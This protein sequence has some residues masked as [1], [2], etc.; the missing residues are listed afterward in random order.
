MTTLASGQNSPNALSVD[1][2]SVYWVND[3]DGT[4]LKLT[5]K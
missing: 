4:V 5:P 3:G 1:V 2:T